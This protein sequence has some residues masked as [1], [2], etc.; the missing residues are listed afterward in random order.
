MNTIVKPTIILTLVTLVAVYT[1]SFVREITRENIL[2]REKEKEENALA[3][4]LP[5]Y[6]LGPENRVDID[7]T[8]FRY[9]EGTLQGADGVA[10]TAHAF[11]TSGPGYSGPVITMV[12]VDEKGTVIGIAIQ[13]Q[14]ETPGLGTR[15]QE[16]ASTKTFVGEMCYLFDRFTGKVSC[17]RGEDEKIPWFQ[18]QFSG[19]DLNKPVNIVKRGD[20]N[21]SM[22][23]QLLARNGVTTI[24][25]ATVTTRAVIRSLE[26]GIGRLRKA[27]E[28]K[29][30]QQAQDAA[31][32]PGQ[33]MPGQSIP[34]Q[35]MRQP[36]MQPALQGQRTMPVQ[37]A[38]AQGGV[39]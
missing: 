10:L 38:P 21:K 39:R 34:G 2:K 13:Q 8:P 5:G 32:Q 11:L 35:T 3:L 31:T 20:W 33:A 30:A 28:M 25:G 9:W 24:T 7:G 29:A 18:Q 6:Q 36:T 1:L 17:N 12:G 26:S 37:T 16:I 23:D 19:L 15:S 4:V 22:K 14:T 27:L